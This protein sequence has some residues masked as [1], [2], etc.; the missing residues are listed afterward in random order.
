MIRPRCICSTILCFAS[1]LFS[2]S[3]PS[4]A[5]IDDRVEL[6]GTVRGV[7]GKACSIEL[8]SIRSE[9]TVKETLCDAAGE[10][11]FMNVRRGTYNLVVH[12]GVNTYSQQ[13]ELV[14]PREEVEIKIPEQESSEGSV[15]VA[16]LKIPGKAKNELN[17]ASE[18]LA[19]G[20]LDKA[21]QHATKALEIAPKYARAMTMRA[22]VMT[23]RRQY[24]PALAMLDQSSAIDPMLPITEYVRASIL[25]S[26]GRPK[27]AEMAAQQGLRLDGSWQ[28]HYEMARALAMQSNFEKALEEINHATRTA[29]PHFEPVALLHASLLAKLNNVQAARQVLQALPRQERDS[30]PAAQLLSKLGQFP[31]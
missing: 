27:D 16:E 25:N 10:F 31:R 28:G 23:A 2:L 4:A 22:V 6:V 19:K 14:S 8:S 3:L 13:L 29:P 20:E 30:G 26:L 1:L 12:E 21:D 7:D 17:K 15:S 18:L 24:Q 11:H 5:Q 9:I